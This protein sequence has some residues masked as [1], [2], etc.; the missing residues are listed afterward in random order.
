MRLV[1]VVSHSSENVITNWQFQNKPRHADALWCEN[2]KD[3]TL[4][5]AEAPPS[6]PSTVLCPVV[7][8]NKCCR[9]IPS[10]SSFMQIPC[11]DGS[12]VRRLWNASGAVGDPGSV[13]PA[14]HSLLPFL[15]LHYCPSIVLSVCQRGSEPSLES[16]TS[17]IQVGCELEARSMN[18]SCFESFSPQKLNS[19]IKLELC[20][21]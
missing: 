13:D 6:P 1:F 8:R 19:Y 20:S 3:D 16:P 2:K 12:C 10:K 9:E 17:N 21:Y 18:R 4:S 5:W 11:M 7:K 14:T 15:S